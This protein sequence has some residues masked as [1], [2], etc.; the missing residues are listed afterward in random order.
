MYR[1]ADD[2]DDQ[3]F[4]STGGI[5]AVGG[6]EGEEEE[7]DIERIEFSDTE[8]YLTSEEAA[9]CLCMLGKNDSGLKYSYL[10]MNASNKNLTDISVIPTFRNV[11]FVNVSGNR[12]S[13]SSLSV[14][15]SMTYLLMLRADKN[16]LKSAEIEP[17]LYLQVLSMNRNQISDTLGVSHRLLECLE[18]NNNRIT[19]V[20]LNP[21]VLEN[22]KVL[23]LRENLLTT[24]NGIFFPSLVSL[25]VANNRISMIE[26][27]ETLV[28]LKTFHAR[29]NE[30]STLD[31]F[32]ETNVKLSYVNLRG[33]RV[34]E[35]SEL[36]KL[37]KLKGLETLIV[38][39]NPVTIIDDE[40]A[41]DESPEYRIKL[42]AAIPNLKRINKDPVLDEER[43]EAQEIRRELINE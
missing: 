36:V 5:S 15:S 12:L 18:L 26:G 28:N 31:G 11:V 29:G 40:Q 9:R 37:G 14:L 10:M 41:E 4:N 24:T 30:I 33:N 2:D 3:S 7:E 1:S 22:L 8:V 32:G 17:M 25:Y 39:E 20:N 27:F 16:V 23:E 35:F 13:Q 34:S 21:Y 42:I 6:E 19:T 43:E 38:S